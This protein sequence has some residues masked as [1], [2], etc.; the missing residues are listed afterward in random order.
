MKI[1]DIFQEIYSALVSNRVRSGLTVLGIVIGISSVIIMTAIGAG[2]QN[3]ITDSIQSI[4]SNLITVNPGAQR[5]PGSS[6]VSSK[7]SANSLT[8][9]DA[10][11]I[12]EL[13][14]VVGVSPEIT[15][16]YQVVYKSN[17]TNT[18]IAGVLPDY[19]LVRNVE[20]E[21]GVFVL[22]QNVKSSSKVA[23]LGATVA[24]DLFG[25]DVSS[26]IG[27]RVRINSIQ[28]KVVGVTESKGGTG[29]GSTDDMVFI[30]VT[31]ASRYLTGDEYVSS[32]SVS[33]DDSENIEI[34]EEELTEL[35]LIRHKIDNP[36]EADFYTLNQEDLMETASSV[37]KT[38]T[39]LLAAIAS[40][41]LLVGGIGIMNM[42]L[43]TVTERTREIGLRKAIGAKRRD[44]NLQFLLEAVA[45]TLIGGILGILLGMLVSYF[46]NKVGVVDSDIS[47]LSVVLAFGVSTL[48]GI[49][50]GYYPAR[51]ASKLNP[52]DALRYE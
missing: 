40:I 16:R 19:T 3:S 26:A 48:I 52:I 17:N 44:I 27:Q 32:V 8:L 34:L 47:M 11:A 25:D 9:D 42:M 45:L 43:T 1:K 36:E 37:T 28:F 6:V 33:A 4:G 50:F 21:Q 38:L 29:F 35:L 23:V 51:R 31:T 5:I 30:P 15:N 2:A 7:G 13:S 22:D 49:T 12:D 18:T 14:H 41:S 20:V 24:T 39:I 10:Y 46:I